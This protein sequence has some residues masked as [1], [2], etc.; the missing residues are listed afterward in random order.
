MQRSELKDIYSLGNSSNGRKRES[1]YNKC[2][3]LGLPVDENDD[4]VILTLIF[5]AAKAKYNYAS[6][7]FDSDF[8]P[9]EKKDI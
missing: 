1:L 5:E 6:D 9:A 2:V 3:E 4:D 8:N 7:E